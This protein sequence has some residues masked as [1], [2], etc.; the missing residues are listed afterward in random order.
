M[1]SGCTHAIQYHTK[2][3]PAIALHLIYMTSL[4]ASF[5]LG[6]DWRRFYLQLRY[7]VPLLEHKTFKTAAELKA[8][9]QRQSQFMMDE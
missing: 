8:L 1:E 2:G 6:D 9:A 7:L 5:G 4:R 3:C